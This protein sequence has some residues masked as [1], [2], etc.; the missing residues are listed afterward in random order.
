MWILSPAL[1]KHGC[2]VSELLSAVEWLLY[3]FLFFFG[4]QR[5]LYV[6]KGPYFIG[7]MGTPLL[8]RSFFW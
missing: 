4:G 8:C 2:Q 6:L 1:C 7:Q 3:V 5:L